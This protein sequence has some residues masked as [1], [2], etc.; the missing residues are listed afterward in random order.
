MKIKFRCP[1]CLGAFLDNP[2]PTNNAILG[3]EIMLPLQNSAVYEY[4]CPNG[5]FMKVVLQNPK[6]EL[7]FDSGISSL[8][9]WY[10][11]EAITSFAVALERFY[12]Y[13]IR[14][15]L[16]SSVYELGEEN[17]AKTWKAISKQSERQIGA[18]YLI[19]LT[20]VKQ[21]APIFDS[22]FLKSISIKLG[23]EGNDPVNFRNNV[24]HQGYIPTFEQA[25]N[26]GEAVNLYIK[27]LLK[28]YKNFD[29]AQDSP[30]SII[31]ASSTRLTNNSVKADVTGGMHIPTFISDITEDESPKGSS[32]VEYIQKHGT[33]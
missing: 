7:I 11:R 20:V 25:V 15:L 1:T 9:K 19:Y 16:G 26:F 28:I 14:V 30:V 32:L 21:S 6:H 3:V 22:S 5:H 12:E 33:L 23:I 31:E 18:F 8:R 27:R 2:V 13:S 29:S 24:I 4:S 10:Y 17:W